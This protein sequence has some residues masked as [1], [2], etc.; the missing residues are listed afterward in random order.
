MTWRTEHVGSLLRPPELMN[1]RLALLQGQGDPG[2]LARLEDEA[3]LQVLE[4]QREL[5][6]DVVGDGE[7]RRFSFI[8]E[9]AASVSGFAF[10]QLPNPDWFTAEGRDNPGA[11]AMIAAERLEPRRRIAQR[12]AAFLGAHAAGPFKVTLPSP[13]V[14]AQAGWTPERSSAAYPRRADLMWHVADLLREEIA[15][16]A[17]EGVPYVQIDNPGLAHY[18]DPALAERARGVGIEIDIPLEEALAADHH[19][20]KD[21]PEE[22]PVVGLHLCRGN[23]RSA[24]LAQGGYEPVAEALFSLPRVNRL[25]LEFDTERAGSFEPLRLVPGDKT[26]VL[27]LVSTKQ[28]SLEDEEALLRKVEAAS[29]HLPLERLAISPQCGFATSIPGNRITPEEQWAKLERVVSLAARL[30]A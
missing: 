29:R 24:W 16:L 23:W 2:A 6:L 1:L 26:V 19:C 15:A 20:V 21:L 10:G 27:G 18:L 17:A 9:I 4:R 7:F 11:N 5:G 22:G 28:G 3:I 13:L 30:W 25:L 8:G 12:E 14:I